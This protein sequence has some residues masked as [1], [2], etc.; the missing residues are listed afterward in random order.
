MLAFVIPLSCLATELLN[1]DSPDGTT[2]SADSDLRAMV[3]Q[4]F[5]PSVVIAR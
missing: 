2:F 4:P 5:L 3:S 1:A